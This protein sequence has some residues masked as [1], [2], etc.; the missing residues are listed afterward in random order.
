[1]RPSKNRRPQM[2]RGRERARLEHAHKPISPI[3]STGSLPSRS[4]VPQ[5]ESPGSNECKTRSASNR[6]VKPWARPPAGLSSTLTE[7]PTKPPLPPPLGLRAESGDETRSVGTISSVRQSSRGVSRLARTLGWPV[8]GV[9]RPLHWWLSG[10]TDAMWL[11]RC[12]ED[13]DRPFYH[14]LAERLRPPVTVRASRGEGGVV[15]SCGG[16]AQRLRVRFQFLRRGRSQ[17]SL[18]GLS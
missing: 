3:G 2:A 15:G 7:Q 10:D 1:M 9:V 16:G 14:G 4:T 18:L 12:G 17:M 11:D 6:S 8:R 13:A 5:E